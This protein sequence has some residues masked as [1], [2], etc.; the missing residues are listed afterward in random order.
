MLA[1]F[2]PQFVMG[3]TLGMILSPDEEM[4]LG[5]GR[6]SGLVP[7]ISLVGLVVGFIVLLFIYRYLDKVPVRGPG[8]EYME[9][10]PPPMTFNEKE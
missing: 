1:F 9:V 2:V 4:N 6:F 8:D 10:P 7:V 3:F 5:L